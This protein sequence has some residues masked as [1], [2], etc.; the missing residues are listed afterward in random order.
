MDNRY[1]NCS[2]SKLD[3]FSN[4]TFVEYDFSGGDFKDAC[5][6]NSIFRGCL[7][8][9]GVP[10]NLIFFSSNFFNCTFK[11]FDF[12]RVII[13][14]E[15]GLFKDCQ[16]LRCNFSG[17][18]LE[19][20]HFDGC[21]FD[22]CKIKGVSFNDSSFLGCRFVGRLEDTTFNGLYHKRSTGFQILDR[23]D[24]SQ[25]VFGDFVTFEDCDLSTCTPP[26]GN[27]FEDLLYAIYKNNPKILS[28]GSSDRI[29]LETD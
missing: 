16:F 27:T 17:Q 14:A 28:T 25:A 26:A 3:G 9:G 6:L 19:S 4:G 18:Q 10:G 5:F 29:V 7:F 20:P 13:G 1:V 11:N 23:V 24:F 22:H 8:Q 12:R 15:G 21:L 2:I